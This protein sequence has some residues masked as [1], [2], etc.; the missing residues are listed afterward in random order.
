MYFEESNISNLE[1][2]YSRKLSKFKKQTLIKY[3][4][5]LNKAR[6]KAEIRFIELF[7]DRYS[8]LHFYKN[9][10]LFNKY[11]A[12]FVDIDN[13]IIVEIDEQHH[14]NEDQ[15]KKDEKRQKFLEKKGYS[16]LR[17]SVTSSNEEWIDTFDSFYKKHQKSVNTEAC[18]VSFMKEYHRK[19]QVKQK[20]FVDKI[21]STSR[22]YVKES[23]NEFISRGG[24][25]TRC[26]TKGLP[27]EPTERI[28]LSK[29]GNISCIK[30]EKTM[31]RNS[32]THIKARVVS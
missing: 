5:Q 16:V 3:C 7:K 13:H 8:E 27:N 28:S 21:D 6:Y 26:P 15:R 9:Y 11:F 29:K 32:S 19:K 20:K 10:P 14:L 22:T 12:D 24:S 4:Q 2:S 1:Y 31:R 25:I 17:L 30:S 18:D 23:L